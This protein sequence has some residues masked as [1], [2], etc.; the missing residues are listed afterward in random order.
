MPLYF[1]YSSETLQSSIFELNRVLTQLDVPYDINAPAIER[2][3]AELE[4]CGSPGEPV[5]WLMMA[6]LME[7]ALLCAGNYADNSEISAAGDLLL[8][9]REIVVRDYDHG[10][11]RIT[12]RQGFL[13]EQSG[14]R[15]LPW[16]RCGR[17]LNKYSVEIVTPALLPYLAAQLESSRC[18]T[19]SYLGSVRLRMCKLADTIG[20]LCAGALTSMETLHHYIRN[21][22]PENKVFINANLCCFD[23]QTYERLGEEIESTADPDFKS[24]FIVPHPF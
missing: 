3:L 22:S 8:N 2:Y 20:F 4:W 9:P 10:K 21:D 5:Y 11:S 14:Q 16:N 24:S 18:I 6:R 15:R 13:S 17:L 23:T 19:R 1:Q 7:M 12:R